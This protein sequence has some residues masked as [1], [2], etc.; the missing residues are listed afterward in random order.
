MEDLKEKAKPMI[1]LQGVEGVEQEHKDI[2]N[3]N[4]GS[5]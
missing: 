5:F 3:E 1:L 4:Y 2:T